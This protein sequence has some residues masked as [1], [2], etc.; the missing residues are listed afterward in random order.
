MYRLLPLPIGNLN[1]Q[2]FIDANINNISYR[3]YFSLSIG[4]YSYSNPT[5]AISDTGTTII[6]GPSDAVDGIANALGASLSSSAVY[7]I[8]TYHN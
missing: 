8:E 7:F 3:L 4:D 6:Y 2:G 5:S 1:Y